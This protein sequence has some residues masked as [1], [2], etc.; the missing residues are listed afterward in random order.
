MSPYP[1]KVLFVASRSDIAGGEVYLLNVMRHLDRSRFQPLIAVPGEGSF[2]EALAQDRVET[3]V[4]DADYGW[5]RPPTAWYRF[6]NGFDDRVRRFRGLIRDR[7]I[8]LVHTNSNMILEGALAAR[9]EGVHHLYL[10][11][12][13]FQPNMPIYER[14]PI[15][16]ASFARLM[17][18]LSSRVIA[19]SRGVASA[20]VPPLSPELVRVILNGLDF[21]EYDR[22]A[23]LGRGELRRELGLPPDALLIASV[24]RLHPDK[25]NDILVR[26]AAEV[27]RQAKPKEV[28][29]F[30]AG[31]DDDKPFANEIR[32]RVKDLGL[33]N[34]FHF[35]G[36][37]SDVPRLLTESDIF[38]LSSRREGH[39]FVLLEAMA[40]G[41]ACVATRCAGVEDTVKDRETA[42]LVEIED[43]SAM[44]AAVV[45]LVRDGELRKRFGTAARKEVRTCHD[46]KASV[47]T[48]MSEYEEILST[49]PP[50]AGSVAVDLF[51]RAAHELGSL[52][53][54]VTEMEERLRQLEHLAQNLRSNPIYTSARRVKRWFQP[55][56]D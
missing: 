44:A 28:H 21:E 24:G 22:V 17:G 11:H 26:C 53:A 30:H 8:D 48:L 19:V 45:E 3:I 54:K 1:S 51:V 27:V 41:C 38:V 6:L 50:T 10:A 20:L 52:G 4:M 39:P 14:V 33:E 31:E 47:A 16:R 15:S 2:S 18:E 49:S 40:G 32:G 9:S 13:E 5:L 7:G 12:I 46:A 37:R 34:Q 43:S 36:R 25:G 56:Q 55:Q 23:Q 42:L 29:F 35:L